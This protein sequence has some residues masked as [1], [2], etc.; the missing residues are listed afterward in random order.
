M[1]KHIDSILLGIAAV[2]SIAIATLIIGTYARA[3]EPQVV[4][5]NVIPTPTPRPVYRVSEDIPEYK[6]SKADVER[7]AKLLWSSPLR[8]ESEKTKLVWVVLNRLDQGEP[9]GNTVKEVVNDS[10]FTFFDRHSR[11][12][13][14]NR[15][16]VESIMTLWKAEKDGYFIGRRPSKNALYCRFCGE[17]NRKLAMLEEP[18]G[19]PIE[20]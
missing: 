16:L 6:H 11:V 14:K 5:I 7:I 18:S 10:E 4:T 3:D 8:S 9:F 15:K 2:T 19:K 17:G 20:Y 1:K 13:D 12:S